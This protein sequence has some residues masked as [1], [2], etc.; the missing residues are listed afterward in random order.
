MLTLSSPPSPKASSQPPCSRCSPR[1][2]RSAVSRG[3]RSNVP[4]TWCS[5]T[6]S[7][8]IV[9]VRLQ[10]GPPEPARILPREERID[11]ARDRVATGSGV[12]RA[13]D[14][15]EVLTCS[16]R[17]RT[18]GPQRAWRAPGRSAGNRSAG[19][20]GRALGSPGSGA[21]LGRDRRRPAR[22]R[23][24]RRRT[25]R[26]RRRSRAQ[27]RR[28]HRAHARVAARAGLRGPVRRDGRRRPQRRRHGR[29]RAC[30]DRRARGRRPGRRSSPRARGPT[31]GPAKCGRSPKASPQRAPP[32]R[33]RRSGGSPTPTSSTTRARWRGS[34]RPRGPSAARSSRRW[35]RCTVRP[36]RNDC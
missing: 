27:R 26:A 29:S 18:W 8:V 20:V 28:R 3:T 21:I 36:A 23:R 25:G 15:R 31:A 24:G 33:V 9:D 19:G 11:S 7:A 14:Y 32:A 34:W 5:R 13:Q 17:G 16:M 22:A 10:L 12:D 35:S 1:K 4:Q 6:T 2:Y 30:D